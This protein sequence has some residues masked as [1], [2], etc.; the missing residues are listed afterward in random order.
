MSQVIV[1][2]NTMATRR[3]RQSSVKF[4]AKP[5]LMIVVL[6][7][8]MSFLSIMMLVSFNK[9]STKGYTIKYLEVQKQQLWEENEVLKKDLLEKKAISQMSYSA[10]AESM[11]RPGDVA[12]ISGHN[13]VALNN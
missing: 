8:F 9:V 4:E 2:R 10:K 12:Y 1:N 11:V 7:V 13:T 3:R 5:F 6:G